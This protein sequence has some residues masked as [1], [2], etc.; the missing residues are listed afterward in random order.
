MSR[1]SGARRTRASDETSVPSSSV[2]FE[3][4]EAANFDFTPAASA[5]EA[6]KPAHLVT[7][8]L[9][10][11]QIQAKRRRALRRFGCG[12]PVRS[13][14][15]QSTSRTEGLREHPLFSIDR[16]RQGEL[17]AGVMDGRDLHERDRE[18]LWE[19]ELARMFRGRIR[20]VASL[21]LLSLPV[22]TAFYFWF[23]P[24]TGRALVILNIWLMLALVGVW[25][26]SRG[27]RSL[28]SLRL[29]AL[30]GY[31][32]FP[33]S[34]A[35]VIPLVTRAVPLGDSVSGAM[36]FVV[37]AA[38]VHILLSVLLL[39]FVLGEAALAIGCTLA[40]VAYGLFR[41]QP[42][43]S[44]AFNVSQILV[45]GL[46]ATLILMQCH[47]AA[48][49]RRRVFDAAFDIALQAARIQEI[50]L[51]DPLTGGYNRRHIER[52]LDGELARAA[53]FERPLSLVMFDLDNF[54]PINDTYGH[55]AGDQVLRTIHD[56]ANAV[57]REVDTLA[58]YGGDE[59]L[60]VLPETDRE[61]TLAITRRLC[62]AA[63]S[64]LNAHFGPDSLAGRVTLSVGVL[65]LQAPAIDASEVL[66]RVD[67]LLYD[68][69]RGGK[70][71]VV[72]G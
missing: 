52:V 40:A 49:L 27:A 22:F 50:S 35:F 23:A 24:Q 42:L 34:A 72:A 71:R 30:A 62:A 37:L 57:L 19:S 29:M 51:C 54:K 9:S 16:E 59:F 38:F 18:P 70:S 4:D 28:R 45:L 32:V 39:P 58:R 43:A 3:P 56:A 36:Q 15:A 2:S 12:R 8:A 65:T 17:P 11:A 55:A 47:L 26:V 7:R 41:A 68:A 10:R 5:R 64:G 48:M 14:S 46:T 25:M 20:L 33:M 6:E 60:I 67:S 53:R 61:S 13:K 31:V 1:P 66:A 63:Q 69:K 21:G 44:N